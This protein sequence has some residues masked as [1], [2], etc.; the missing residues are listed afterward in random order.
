MYQ[1]VDEHLKTFCQAERDG[2]TEEE[3]NDAM[4]VYPLPNYYT[5]KNARLDMGNCVSRLFR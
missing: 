4:N 5:E 1:G 2:P 3:I